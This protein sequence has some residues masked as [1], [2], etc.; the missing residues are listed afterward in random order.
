[1]TEPATEVEQLGAKIAAEMRATA[2]A[3]NAAQQAADRLRADPRRA[4]QQARDRAQ[5]D[6]AELHR[7]RAEKLK[8]ELEGAEQRSRQRRRDELLGQRGERLARASA[9]LERLTAH[10]AGVD[11]E[12]AELSRIKREADNANGQLRQL[13]FHED[14]HEQLNLPQPM[15]HELRRWAE[16]LQPGPRSR[17]NRLF[18]PLQ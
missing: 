14:A 6:D 1:M 2:A 12:L 5:A 13:N 3:L 8:R 16:S 11:A 18:H 10:R 7:L 4:H 9:S 15:Q 17:L